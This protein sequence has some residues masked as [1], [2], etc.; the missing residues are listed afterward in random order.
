[1]HVA[2]KGVMFYHPAN[3]HDARE[4]D[5]SDDDTDGATEPCKFKDKC[6]AKGC[7]AS[8]PF[9]CR[10]GLACRSLSQQA[11]AG[12]GGGGAAAPVTCKWVHP[13]P[14]SVVPLGDAFPLNTACKFSALCTN[15]K[16]MFAHPHGRA[17]R[18]VRPPK[19]LKLTRS[20]NLEPLDEPVAIELP[21]PGE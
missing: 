12:A 2:P 10:F 20:L 5:V 9:P 7:K 1:M 13:S 14:D 21:M 18:A 11:G 3:M 16:C 17:T 6:T 4:V 8:H 19:Q 15:K